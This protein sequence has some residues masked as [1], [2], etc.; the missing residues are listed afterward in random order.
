MEPI[1]SLCVYCGSAVGADPI[2]R[3]S[4]VRLGQLMAEN[5][6]RLIYGGGR[7]GLMGVL[8]D[9]VIAHG[10]TAVGVIPEFLETRE[11]GHRG[12]TTLHV[13]DSMH[14]RKNLMFDESDAFAILP[15]GFGTLDEAFEIITWR[16]LKLHD[17]PIV[18]IDVD[19]YW[20]PFLQL[21]DHVIGRGFARPACRELFTVVSTVDEVLD[22]IRREPEPA[23]PDLPERL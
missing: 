12:V 9:A 23:V 3:E 7:I 19:G 21:V 1:S 11:V 10:G 14:T 22:A 13:V 20:Q 4:A 17:K 5:R 8:A 2:F 16:Q 6:I 18:M 15:G